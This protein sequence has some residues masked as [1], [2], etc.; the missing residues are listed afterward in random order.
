MD[1]CKKDV[2]RF[3]CWIIDSFIQTLDKQEKMEF[4]EKEFKIEELSQR[5]FVKRLSWGAHKLVKESALEV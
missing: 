4:N 3:K 1:R 5:F 2:K